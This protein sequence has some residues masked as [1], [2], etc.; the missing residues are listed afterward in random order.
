[1][2]IVNITDVAPRDAGVFKCSVSKLHHVESCNSTI[3]VK[4]MFNFL[5]S[6]LMAAASHIPIYSFN[7]SDQLL[8]SY[9]MSLS[10]FLNADGIRLFNVIT[11]L[12]DQLCFQSI[13]YNMYSALQCSH[14]M[15]HTFSTFPSPSVSFMPIPCMLSDLI[16]LQYV[17]STSFP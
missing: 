5:P 16:L 12:C 2:S 13:L 9:S 17:Y 6:S 11:C 15:I 10:S 7:S 4:G 1:M 8:N 14:L 3:I